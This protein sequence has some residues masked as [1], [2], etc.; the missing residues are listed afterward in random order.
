MSISNMEPYADSHAKLESMKE[1]RG[2]LNHDPKLLLLNDKFS[3]SSA[4]P[5][6]LN[7]PFGS[8]I[9]KYDMRLPLQCLVKPAAGYL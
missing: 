3:T 8:H 6:R 7:F 5:P 2:L 9:W 4:L 1:P